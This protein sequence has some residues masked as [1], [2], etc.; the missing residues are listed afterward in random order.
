M[1]DEVSMKVTLSQTVF[2]LDRGWMESW[3]ATQAEAR[4]SLIRSSSYV[5]VFGSIFERRGLGHRLR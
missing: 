1:N 2:F 4:S 5:C 3:A